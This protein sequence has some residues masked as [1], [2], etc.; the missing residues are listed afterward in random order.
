MMVSFVAIAL[1]L[2]ISALAPSV[3]AA[4]AF[5]TPLVIVG[6]LFGGFYISVNSLPIV[7]NWIPYFSIFKWGFQALMV[8]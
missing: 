2:A 7:A 5:G 6:I 4:S 3:E 8:S 1:G